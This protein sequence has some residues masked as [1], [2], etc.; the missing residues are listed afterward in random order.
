MEIKYLITLASFILTFSVG[1]FWLNTYSK[2]ISDFESSSTVAKD[3]FLP[4]YVILFISF[5]V[6][7]FSNRQFFDFIYQPNYWSLLAGF[8]SAGMIYLG[9][10]FKKSKKYTPLIIL[11][12]A[13]GCSLLLPKDFLLFEGNLPLI[14]DRSI[15]ILLWFLFSFSYKY[16]NGID[17]ILSLQTMTAGAGIFFISLLGGAPLL[18]GNYALSLVG[19]SAAFMAFSWYPA[20]IVLK[21]GAASALGFIVAWLIMQS[22]VEK[23]A[24][25]NLIFNLFFLTEI[26]WATALKLTMRPQYKNIMSNMNYYQANISG[27]APNFVCNATAKLEALLLILGT[28]QIYA[29]NS[30]SLPIISFI[31]ALWFNS[32]IKNWQ[33]RTTSITEINTN[34]V[35]DIKDNV[36]DINL[37]HKQD[38]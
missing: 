38:K 14:L 24:S 4:L 36:N 33:E 6:L 26:I 28:F 37:H 25:C 21:Q 13:I 18:L 2:H 12:A 35:R 32:K 11:S 15:V 29:P 19:V 10:L 3:S 27:L 8:L 7:F 5:T 20:R 17:G 9:S 31:L 22:S 34:F 30:Y 23:A 1:F 16:I